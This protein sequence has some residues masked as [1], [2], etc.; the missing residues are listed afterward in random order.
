VPQIVAQGNRLNEVLVQPKETADG[1]RNPGDQLDME[2]SVTDVVVIDQGKNLGFVNVATITP[3]MQYTVSILS[4]GLAVVDK[5]IRSSAHGLPAH[6]SQG[7]KESF[8]LGHELPLQFCQ[9][10]IPH[11]SLYLQ[12]SE[13]WIEFIP[14]HQSLFKNI[15]F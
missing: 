15:K 6:R 13:A 5:P 12:A 14:V 3:G 7:R 1:S 11:A 8:L 2:N 4:K 9:Q 10:T